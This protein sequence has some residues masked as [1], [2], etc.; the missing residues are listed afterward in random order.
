VHIDV[1]HDFSNIICRLAQ[2]ATSYDLHTDLVRREDPTNRLFPRIVVDPPSSDPTLVDPITENPSGYPEY[3]P[4]MNQS[5]GSHGSGLSAGELAGIIIGSIVGAI[6]LG[7]LIW[8]CI[9]QHRGE[10]AGATPKK[11]V[12]V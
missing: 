9:R 10:G 12:E 2:S 4:N 5:D 11:V 7:L 6:I 8:Y 3:D 1:E